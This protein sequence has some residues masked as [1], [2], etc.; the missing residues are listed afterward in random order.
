MLLDKR[1]TFGTADAVSTSSSSAKFIVGSP[2]NLGAAM[3]DFRG[4][5]IYDDLGRAGMNFL[6]IKVVSSILKGGGAGQT[7]AFKLLTHST[8]SANAST[9]NSSGTLI[10]QSR[11]FSISNSSSSA[12]ALGA[13]VALNVGIEAERIAQQYLFLIGIAAGTGTLASGK[14]TAWIGPQAEAGRQ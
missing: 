8:S 12:L 14:L 2:L 3:K 9:V 5:T 4:S 6:N 7:V 13:K 1:L 11:T 10:W